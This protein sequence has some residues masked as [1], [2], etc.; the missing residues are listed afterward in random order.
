MLKWGGGGG[1]MFHPFKRGMQKCFRLADFSFCRALYLQMIN[2]W[3][4]TMSLGIGQT[5]VAI[6][7]RD[8]K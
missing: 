7:S 2:D 4:L 1:K 6:Y 3:S 5:E 8:T